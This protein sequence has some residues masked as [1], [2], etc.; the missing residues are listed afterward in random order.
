MRLLGIAMLALAAVSYAEPADAVE[1]DLPLRIYVMPWPT[2][3]AIG[4]IN[5]DGLA[6]IVT[7]HGDTH[8]PQYDNKVAIS[9]QR[10]SGNFDRPLVHDCQCRIGSLAL[11]RDPRH[12]GDNILIL[13]E[14]DNRVTP[15]WGFAVLDLLPDNTITSVRYNE[16]WLG[17]RL[18]AIV[19]VNQDDRQDLFFSYLFDDRTQPGNDFAYALWYGDGGRGVLGDRTAT[20]GGFT[21]YQGARFI[22]SGLSDPRDTFASRVASE[23]DIDGDGYLDLI[24]GRCPTECLYRQEPFRRMKMVPMTMETGFDGAGFN[25]FADIDGDGL[26]DRALVGSEGRALHVFMQQPG[27]HFAQWGRL[28]DLLMAGA[29]AIADLDNNGLNDVV[30]ASADGGAA[31]QGWLDMLMQH[32]EGGFELQSQRLI[33]TTEF[34]RL[35]IQDVDRDGCRDIVMIG[36]KGNSRESYIN[37]LRGSGCL[38]ASDRAVTVSTSGNLLSVQVRHEQGAAIPAGRILRVV[39]APTVEGIDDSGLSVMPPAGCHG[40]GAEPPRRMFDCTLTA[41]NAGEE[42]TL[43]FM[44]SF[45]PFTPSI[46]LDA[47]AFLLGAPDQVGANNRERVVATFNVPASGPRGVH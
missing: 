30:V 37:Y 22:Y 4:D 17:G 18:P 19:D 11:L 29:P 25:A 43:S 15:R 47:S 24:E 46:E 32:P 16:P 44:L 34:P 6:D 26:S 28:S 38:P 33:M 14:T 13:S 8:V 20:R 31:G 12:P 40:V 3:V 10:P 42:A 1:Y 21:R 9:L 2:A 36:L 27:R 23:V 35:I 5:G 39:V 7:A 45:T 41:S